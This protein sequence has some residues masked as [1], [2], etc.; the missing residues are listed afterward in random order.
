MSKKEILLNEIERVPDNLLDELLDF[1]RFLKLK[2]IMDDSGILITSESS[3][4]KDWLKQE[5]D[6]AWQSL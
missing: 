4:A 1:I 5:E 2:M 6:Q 3:L